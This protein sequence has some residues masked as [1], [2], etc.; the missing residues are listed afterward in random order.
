MRLCT[1]KQLAFRNTD[2]I[3][4]DKD[5]SSL[6]VIDLDGDKW[7][8]SYRTTCLIAENPRGFRISFLPGWCQLNYK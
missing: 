6:T 2:I 4:T 3:L 5:A 8:V 1:F 7:A